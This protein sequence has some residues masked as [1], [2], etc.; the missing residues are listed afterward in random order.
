M[1][2]ITK[3]PEYLRKDIEMVEKYDR[4]TSS[5]YDCYLDEVWGSINSC[6]ADGIISLSDA[7]ELR[8]KYYW[9]NILKGVEKND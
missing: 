7:E 8:K 6:W 5:V 1:I 3:L 9:D 2:D 4:T